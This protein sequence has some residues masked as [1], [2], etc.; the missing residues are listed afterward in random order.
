MTRQGEISYFKPRAVHSRRNGIANQVSSAVS[1]SVIALLPRGSD[2]ADYEIQM[3]QSQNQRDEK[4]VL[5]G[6]KHQRE[7]S[8][9]RASL[10]AQNKPNDPSGNV[11]MQSG[12]VPTMILEQ[13]ERL[14]ITARNKRLLC[15]RQAATE[16]LLA[17]LLNVAPTDEIHAFPRQA[18]PSIYT[19]RQQQRL[20]LYS[21]NVSAQTSGTN[22]EAHDQEG[23][24]LTLPLSKTFRQRRVCVVEP[25]Q[26]ENNRW[27]RRTAV[28]LATDIAIRN[29]EHARV[30]ARRF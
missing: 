26:N 23:P 9:R 21:N 8:T 5:I 18:I 22:F 28:C 4:Q 24:H 27:N 2:I 25:V 14:T 16:S 6:V 20:E 3:Q 11:W 17:A 13:T 19:N 15:C 30:V 29:R 12:Y 7:N 1:C 10:I